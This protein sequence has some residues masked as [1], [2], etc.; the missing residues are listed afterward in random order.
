MDPAALRQLAQC[1]VDAYRPLGSLSFAYAQGSLVEGLATQADFDLVLVWTTS[2]PAH[3]IRVPVT[4]ADPQPLPESF[5]ERGFNLDRFYVDGQQI[6]AKHVTM[7]DVEGWWSAVS[8]GGGAAGY[9]MPAIAL[10]G[11]TSGMIVFDPANVGAELVARCSTVPTAFVDGAW[12]RAQEA[13]P[14]FL[15]ELQRSVDREDAL[16]FHDHLVQVAR[17]L[18]IA[19]YAKQGLWWPHEKRLA[20]RLRQMGSDDLAGIEATLWTGSL[21]ER[22][23]AARRL[24]AAV[25]RDT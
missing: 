19:W 25:T 24:A 7:D 1:V 3:N 18:L 14:L 21:H 9:P 11:L 8:A 13:A 12:R 15:D 5:D 4:I 10:H 6:D 20:R 23:E 22:L 2:A 16:L 17:L